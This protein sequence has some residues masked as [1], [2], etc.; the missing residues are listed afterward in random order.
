MNSFLH[1]PIQNLTLFPTLLEI[2][3]LPGKN[4]GQ[5]SMIFQVQLS[6]P[7]TVLLNQE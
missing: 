1:T 7:Q 5:N 4:K 6:L 3:E 2:M